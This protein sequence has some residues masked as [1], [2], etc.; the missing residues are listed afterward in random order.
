MQ[1]TTAVGLNCLDLPP[2]MCA[3][4]CEPSVTNPFLIQGGA[5]YATIDDGHT[6]QTYGLFPV[7]EKWDPYKGSQQVV[8]ANVE[9]VKAWKLGENDLK[10]MFMDYF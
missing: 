6:A 3:G 7:H 9:P 1:V 4:L 8:W 5:P 2:Q 10:L